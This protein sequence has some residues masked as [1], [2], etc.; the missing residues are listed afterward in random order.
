MPAAAGLMMPVHSAREKA[1]RLVCGA[2]VMSAVGGC[3]GGC[4]AA[5]ARTCCRSQN[6]DHAIVVRVSPIP[7]MHSVS[8]C[9][10]NTAKVNVSAM[11]CWADAPRPHLTLCP[12]TRSEPT[13][14]LGG[15]ATSARIIH[16][17]G[18]RSS[19]RV[20]P[21]RSGQLR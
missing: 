8:A 7:S 3:D 5:L 11:R 4:C 19:S 14:M 16:L 9:Q 20:T 2:S 18:L 1:V 10:C 17:L 21:M 13:L 12:K 6:V 15:G